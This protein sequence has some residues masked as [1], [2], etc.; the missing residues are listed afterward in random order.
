M[1]ALK[2]R[3]H[4]NTTDV[5]IFPANFENS[6]PFPT[7]KHNCQIYYY[8]QHVSLIIWRWYPKGGEG[9]QSQFFFKITKYLILRRR[10]Y[11][12][13]SFRVFISLPWAHPMARKFRSCL[14]SSRRSTIQ[15]GP[16]PWCWK[17]RRKWDGLLTSYQVTSWPT[18]KRKI[19]IFGLIP[20]V[21]FL[22][23]PILFLDGLYT[24]YITRS[25]PS[26][27]WQHPITPSSRH[28]N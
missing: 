15:N 21:L 23:T 13:R 18:S 11:A 24:D 4:L 5:Q 1:L 3:N 27:R 19:G 10:Q 14:K 22:S 7:H 6:K 26:D 2:L 20:M 8:T 16:L 17:T 25:Y 28:G 12:E 9:S